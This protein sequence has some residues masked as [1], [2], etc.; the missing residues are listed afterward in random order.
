LDGL[1]GRIRRKLAGAFGVTEA[2]TAPL[3]DSLCRALKKWTTGHPGVTAE[4]LCNELALPPTPKELAPAPPPPGC[5]PV[6]AL[7]RDS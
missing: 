3:F 5:I 1:E 7:G 6:S 4:E 2:R